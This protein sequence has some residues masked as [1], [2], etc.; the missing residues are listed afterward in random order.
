MCAN[1]RVV[2]GDG[3]P[4]GGPERVDVPRVEAVHL[5]E[6]GLDPGGGGGGEGGRGAGPA[7]FVIV[8]NK[9]K[10]SIKM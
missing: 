6:P 9:L 2:P 3:P 10:K 7:V 1:L 5:V 4:A 8:Q